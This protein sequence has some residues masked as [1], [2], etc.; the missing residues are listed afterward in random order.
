MKYG[1]I[2]LLLWFLVACGGATPAAA[3]TLIVTIP[4]PVP[5]PI[6]T[7]ATEPTVE[8]TATIIPTETLQPT[9]TPTAT[10]TPLPTKTATPVPP[11]KIAGSGE[12]VTDAVTLPGSISRV[13]LTHAG[14]RNFIVT[15]YYNDDS[16]DLL[17]NTIGSYQGIRPLP[18]KGSVYFEIKADG[19]WTIDIEP[20]TNEPAAATGL[21][22]TGDYTSGLFS[23]IKA[24]PVP[25]TFIHT[26]KRN[27][28]VQVYC[29]GGGDLAQNSIG[30]VNSSAVVRFERGPCFWEIRADGD[31]SIAPK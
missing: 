20:I 27:F 10:A 31:W 2:I 1:A 6:P 21:T 12:T 3:P 7:E 4:T 9:N 19:A 8:P 16:T 11:V 5:I 18:E 15:A 23:P 25:F 22:G 13:T 17:V 30:A 26:G 29:A 14:R 24:G 28:V